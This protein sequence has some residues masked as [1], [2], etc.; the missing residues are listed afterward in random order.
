MSRAVLQ[1]I[2]ESFPKSAPLMEIGPLTTPFLSKDKFNVYYSDV[3]TTEKIREF[4]N[5]EQSINISEITKIDIVTENKT[6]T[7]AIVA[8]NLGF[9]KFSAVFSSHVIEHT[10]DFIRHLQ[11][12]GDILEENGLYLLCVPDKRFTFDYFRAVTPFRDVYDIYS[13]GKL[14]RMRFDFILNS[15]SNNFP[16]K[17]L[18][19]LNRMFDLKLFDYDFQDAH[20]WVFTDVSF[21]E[22]I[23]DCLRFGLISFGVNQFFPNVKGTEF[24]IVLKKL[25]SSDY[26]NIEILKIQRI[27]D[28]LN[29]TDD[30]YK[31]IA[32][33]LGKFI[34]A[35]KYKP[36]YI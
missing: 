24:Q 6:Y 28:S 19:P 29:G 23:R 9:H 25:N 14:S 11:E 34:T 2:I 17:V 12:I 31:K 7:Q 22:L 35:N 15:T 21:L 13:G 16:Q 33:Q 30:V 36:I 8:A 26:L 3:R 4:Y 20:Y 27:I 32:Q 1:N 10:Y 18:F 5:R